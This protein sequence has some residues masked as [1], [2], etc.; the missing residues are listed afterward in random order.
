M[1]GSKLL[2]RTFL[3]KLVFD[4]TPQRSPPL[5]P[6]ILRGGIQQ[7]AIGHEILVRVGPGPR[8]ARG[9][10]HRRRLRHPQRRIGVGVVARHAG[11]FEVFAEAHFERRPA[12]AEQV[13]GRADS[14]RHVLVAVDAACLRDDDRRS[15]ETATAPPA[16]RGTS[17]RRDRSGARPAA[18]GDRRVHWS[19]TNR[20]SQPTRALFT[21]GEIDSVS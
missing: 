1:P 14:R 6:E 5:G 11:A 10:K 3:P 18:S 7:I 4:T 8:H 20:P 15:A 2:V 16:A 9:A 19:C 12:V 21:H 17:S 13:V